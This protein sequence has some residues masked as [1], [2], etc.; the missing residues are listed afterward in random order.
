MVFNN[1]INDNYLENRK[2]KIVNHLY[3]WDDGQYRN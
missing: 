1:Y 3:N 2:T